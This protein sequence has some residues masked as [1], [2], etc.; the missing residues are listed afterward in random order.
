MDVLNQ[1]IQE[2]L[3]KRGEI[4]NEGYVYPTAR[5]LVTFFESDHVYFTDTNK[6]LG[7]RNGAFGT[8]KAISDNQC[9]VEVDQG[10]HLNF[11]PKTYQGMKLGYA[12]TVYK[13][14]GKSLPQVYV[15]HDK[16]TT[17]KLSYVALTR[18]TE[19]VKIF[20]NQ[21]DPP[22][23]PDFA[24]QINNKKEAQMRAEK[25]IVTLKREL[26]NQ[27]SRPYNHQDISI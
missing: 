18:Q 21:Q 14:Q 20:V 11:D 8:I 27:V 19:E 22:T 5:G 6:D 12:S 23:L 15:F 24:K 4:N 3:L 25:P 16:S 2:V 7:I 9:T 10:Q 1:A 17:Q 26:E 13:S